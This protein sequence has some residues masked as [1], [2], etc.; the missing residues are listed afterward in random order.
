MFCRY[1]PI[2]RVCARTDG[3]NSARART[4]KLLVYKTDTID[5][6]TCTHIYTQTKH[7]V[8]DE[9]LIIYLVLVA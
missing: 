1:A 7:A 5:K 8:S 3:V 9:T 2:A 6:Y 4:C